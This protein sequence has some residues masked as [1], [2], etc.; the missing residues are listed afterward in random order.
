MNKELNDNE[1]KNVNGAGDPI[2]GP[3]GPVT[4]GAPTEEQPRVRGPIASG[5]IHVWAKP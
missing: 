3:D 1:L 4:C 2:G 5:G